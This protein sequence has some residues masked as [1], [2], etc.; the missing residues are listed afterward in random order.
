M[1]VGLLENRARREKS[2]S[3]VTTVTDWWWRTGRGGRRLGRR[4]MREGGV[5]GEHRMKME[6]PGVWGGWFWEGTCGHTYGPPAFPRCFSLTEG[7]LWWRVWPVLEYP[8]EGFANGATL[9]ANTWDF[10]V[11]RATESLRVLW[12]NQTELPSCSFFIRGTW[13]GL[14]RGDLLILKVA[15]CEQIWN[16]CVKKKKKRRSAELS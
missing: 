3:N 4:W 15:S 1:A 7:Y 6:R 11:L 8:L 13:E 2:T 9:S 16:R 5:E 10:Y 14:N 12:C